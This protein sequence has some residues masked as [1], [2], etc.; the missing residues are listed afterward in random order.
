MCRFGF[1]AAGLDNTGCLADLSEE[2]V[3][4]ITSCEQ[5]CLTLGPDLL[6]VRKPPA[7]SLLSDNVEKLP[8]LS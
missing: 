6:L 3:M 1:S 8:L 4:S 2:E 7:C 5:R